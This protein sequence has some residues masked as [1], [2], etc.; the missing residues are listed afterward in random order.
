MKRVLTGFTGPGTWTARPTI[1]AGAYCS[2]PH[3]ERIGLVPIAQMNMFP[4]FHQLLS[5]KLTERT[6]SRRRSRARVGTHL[7]TCPRTLIPQWTQ[8]CFRVV[9]RGPVPV[10][11]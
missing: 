4:N 2:D 9:R 11:K 10:N 8:P 7:A 5:R 1:H 6:C 3:G